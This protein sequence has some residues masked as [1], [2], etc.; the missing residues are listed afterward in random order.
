MKPYSTSFLS[1]ILIAIFLLIQSSQSLAQAPPAAPV[2]VDK[3]QQETLQKPLEWLS[4]GAAERYKN[5]FFP[6]QF[7]IANL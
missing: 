4:D 1:I 2:V 7:R 6:I 3:V 5:V